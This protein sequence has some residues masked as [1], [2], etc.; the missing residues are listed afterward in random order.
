MPSTEL[1]DRPSHAA[2]IHGSHSPILTLDWAICHGKAKNKKHHCIDH[3]CHQGALVCFVLFRS[4]LSVQETC[5]SRCLA[6]LRAALI[7]W[8]G[9]VRPCPCKFRRSMPAA[10]VSVLFLL[11]PSSCQSIPRRRR[12]NPSSITASQRNPNPRRRLVRKPDGPAHDRNHRR[13]TLFAALL[14]NSKLARR[15]NKKHTR[16][17]RIFHAVT[18]SEVIPPFHSPEAPNRASPPSNQTPG[19]EYSARQT[20]HVRA[21]SPLRWVGSV[22]AF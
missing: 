17:G 4:C 22:F 20:P 8:S 9:L 19:P 14:Y 5:R 2:R 18:K 3:T 16:R 15:G 21:A 13:H 12:T 10:R 1:P 11:M 6:R 7:T